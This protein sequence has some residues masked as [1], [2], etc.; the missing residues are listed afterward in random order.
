MMAAIIQLTVHKWA[1]G[2]V[3]RQ[4]T[5]LPARYCDNRSERLGRHREIITTVSEVDMEK[6]EQGTNV[7]PASK[8]R[9]QGMSEYI[10]ITALVAVA[11]IGLFAAF[12]D[13]LQNQIAGMSQEMAG[14][15]GATDITNANTT[16]TR[17]RTR[18]AQADSLSNYNQQTGGG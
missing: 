13:T 8:Q 18:A 16:A 7:R 11:G 10:I 5:A 9:G 4:H 3:I 14:K 1:I 15:S 2:S 17:A 6:F 12:G